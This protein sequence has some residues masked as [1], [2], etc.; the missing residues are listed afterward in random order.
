M[1]LF[2]KIFKRPPPAGVHSAPDWQLITGYGPVFTSWAGELY[3][4][5]QV[6]A[7]VNARAE[8]VAKLSVKVVGSARPILQTRLRIA[9]NEFQTWSQL[10]YRVS[11]IL[12]MQNTA[13]LAPV[14]DET[15]ET[16]GIWPLLPSGCRIV[17]YNGEPWVR[18]Q[19][20][21]GQWTATELR[22]C[23]ILTRHQY[24]DDL[25]GASN[26]ALNP[27]MDMISIQDQGIKAAVK[28][29]NTFRFI[30][31]SNNFL[32]DE[33][34]KKERDRF[35]AENIRGTDS[36]LLLFNSNVSDIRQVTAKPFVVDAEQMKRIDTSIFNY[37]GVNE[38]LLQHKASGD[39]LQAFDDGVVEPFAIQFDDVVTRML[40]SDNEIARGS[41]VKSTMDRMQ[42]MSIQEKIEYSN[43][44]QDRGGLSIDEGRDLFGMEPLPDGLGKK[45]T[46]RGEYYLLETAGTDAQKGGGTNGNDTENP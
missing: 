4:A 31:R 18:W 34:L 23:G 8:R 19:L 3:E 5:G 35:T 11:T 10:L 2:D 37:F 29:S 13:F 43:A 6:R 17:E 39:K 33:D 42:Y 21:G 14:T 27:V 32:N 12:D 45:H 16:V 44:Q 15:G 22:R 9:P 38:D 30:G 41:R 24:K 1:G 46:I 25:F 36:P 7:A 26:A 28:N 40:F 20:S